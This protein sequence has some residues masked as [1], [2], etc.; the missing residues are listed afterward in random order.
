MKNADNSVEQVPMCACV[1]RVCMNVCM[2]VCVIYDTC[3]HI[4]IPIYIYMHNKKISQSGTPLVEQEIK[5]MGMHVV[6]HFPFI[7]IYQLDLRLVLLNY[8]HYLATAALKT[9]FE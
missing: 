7:S 8:I 9:C 2:C 3:I 6:V 1:Y 4:Q 5:K